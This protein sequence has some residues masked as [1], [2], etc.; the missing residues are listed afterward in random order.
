M[1]NVFVKIIFFSKCAECAYD[2]V[3]RKH[4]S[5]PEIFKSANGQGGEEFF[6][7]MLKIEHYWKIFSDHVVPPVV[8]VK[9]E[10]NTNKISQTKWWKRFFENL[11]DAPNIPDEHFSNLYIIFLYNVSQTVVQYTPWCFFISCPLS[12]F[13][14]IFMSFGKKNIAIKTSF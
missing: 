6:E 8:L 4:T 2:K 5:C 13:I 12:K 14:D 9:I 7:N 10:N 11:P 3:L 1:S